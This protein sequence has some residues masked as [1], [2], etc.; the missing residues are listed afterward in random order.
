MLKRH[1]RSLFYGVKQKRE[2]RSI[3]YLFLISSSSE[4]SFQLNLFHLPNLTDSQKPE[5]KNL[6][7]FS[8]ILFLVSLKK[9]KSL[10]LKYSI[11]FIF[12]CKAR[13]LL[14]VLLNSISFQSCL[15]FCLLKLSIRTAVTKFI[16]IICPMTT[17]N[18]KKKQL[19]QPTVLMASYMTYCQSSP[20]T[21]MNTEVKAE[22]IESKFALGLVPF[23]ETQ[24]PSQLNLNSFENRAAPNIVH[25]NVQMK[26]MI[27]KFEMSMNA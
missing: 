14:F 24:I 8:M 27:D 20:Q 26:N 17:K 19:S 12:P 22:V 25:T 2:R 11:D 3:V 16:R 1:R 18:M 4:S 10:C 13:V 21:T 23:S 6:F 5:M 7:P 15:S 9:I